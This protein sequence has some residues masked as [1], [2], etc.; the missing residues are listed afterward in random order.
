MI[1]IINPSQFKTIPWKNGQGK[2]TEL[3][4][5]SSGNLDDFDWRLSIATVA[6]DGL[7]SDFSGYDRNLVLIE[8]NGIS[9]QYDDKK[10]DF[11]KEILDIASFSGKS[12]TY[13]RLVSGAIKDFNIM[14]NNKKI[15]PF[16]HCYHEQEKVVVRL[17][18]SKI[19]FAYSLTDAITV[20]IAKEKNIVVPVGSLIKLSAQV[21][22]AE[23]VQSPVEFSG[24]NMIIIQL[25]HIQ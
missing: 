13:G 21:T 1:E 23:N 9:L 19:C 18:Q 8:G 25:E 24:K 11:L 12:K 5:S 14:T 17:T 16:V 7:F 22:E 15:T 20:D 4:I 6:N 2:T 10:I 3:A